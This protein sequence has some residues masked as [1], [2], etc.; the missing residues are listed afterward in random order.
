MKRVTISLLFGLFCVLS[1]SAQ[2]FNQILENHI[3]NLIAQDAILQ[4][5]ANWLIY[6][7]NVSKIS[8]LQHI[9]FNQ[10]LNNIEIYGTA[11]SIH[12][13]NGETISESNR[14]VLKSSDKLRGSSSPSISAVDAVI[15]AAGQLNYT[16]TEGINVV[17]A[18]VGDSQKNSIKYG[19][20]FIE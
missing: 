12:L 20:D 14:F 17:E 11:S 6:N 13:L 3:N 8:N 7:E 2:N 19:R 10:T 9:Y 15:A 18:A 16:I 1:I 4:E 5:D